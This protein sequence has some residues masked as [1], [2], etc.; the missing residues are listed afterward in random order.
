MWIIKAK[1]SCKD[2]LILSLVYILFIRSNI[3]L[4]KNGLNFDHFMKT[5]YIDI[6]LRTK[7]NKYKASYFQFSWYLVY[8]S[9]NF[10]CLYLYIIDKKYFF[11]RQ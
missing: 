5:E 7:I 6:E 3:G 11:D 2:I 1:P 8:E 9:N 10:L 4:N